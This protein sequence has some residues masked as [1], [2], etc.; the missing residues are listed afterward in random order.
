MEKVT[1]NFIPFIVGGVDL[2][3][4]G[5]YIG[6]QFTSPFNQVRWQSFVRKSKKMKKRNIPHPQ[7]QSNVV[8]SIKNKQRHSLRF[9]GKYKKKL[10]NT[11]YLILGG[12]HHYR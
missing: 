9:K 4:R 5:R 3:I 12:V 8:K 10:Y 11:L 1:H 6:Q 7:I 2:Y